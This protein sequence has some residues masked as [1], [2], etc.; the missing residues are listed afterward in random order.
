MRSVLCLFVLAAL[1]VAVADARSKRRSSGS[2]ISIYRDA[3]QTK[4][5]GKL[6][7]YRSRTL[8]EC[9]NRES[10]L[11]I[12]H[13]A[14]RDAVKYFEFAEDAVY[15][16]KKTIVIAPHMLFSKDRK[17]DSDH[18]DDTI[19]IRRQ[20][21]AGTNVRYPKTEN[22]KKMSTFEIYDSLIIS[23]AKKCKN[24]KTITLAGHSAG[25]QYLQRY[26]AGYGARLVKGSTD[27]KFWKSFQEK[28]PVNF[29]IGNP[30]S[31]MF[32]SKWRP[33]SITK[34]KKS[35]NEY[36]YGLS[37]VKA[38]AWLGKFSEKAL[39]EGYKEVHV[40]WI[41]GDEDTKRQGPLD[42]TCEADTQGKNRLERG[43]NFYKNLKEMGI[44]NHVQVIEKGYG[45][46]SSVLHDEI[47]YTVGS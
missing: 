15:S 29:I 32:M 21:Q 37:G 44:R 19:I 17:T 20:W 3:K 8:S 43:K 31:F 25:G 23:L 38:N 13:G 33:N 22:T 10:A 5:V 18:K 26:A 39:Q 36:K 12:Q 14:G 28:T 45:H 4:A 9:G 35:Y 34:C 1:F 7:Y 40:A 11:I 16:L 27:S 47:F 2:R 30:G 46:T 42:M 41:Q 24:L 6:P